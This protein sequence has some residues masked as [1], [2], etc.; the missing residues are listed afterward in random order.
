MSHWESSLSTGK[1]KVIN[2]LLIGGRYALIR[3]CVTFGLTAV[4]MHAAANI[5]LLCIFLQFIDSS[6]CCPNGHYLGPKEGVSDIV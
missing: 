3:K 2:M 6:Y 4:D 1:P 5:Y